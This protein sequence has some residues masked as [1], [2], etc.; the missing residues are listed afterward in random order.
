MSG[1]GNFGMP[2]Q[3]NRDSIRAD[4]PMNYRGVDMDNA[5]G[6]YNSFDI[7]SHVDNLLQQNSS[8][9]SIA[10]SNAQSMFPRGP[11]FGE[12][13]GNDLL[14]LDAVGSFGG[15][16]LTTQS[17]V[18]P[19][20][21]LGRKSLLYLKIGMI[22]RA[23]LADPTEQQIQVLGM[24][25][26]QIKLV[27]LIRSVSKF[28]SKCVFVL[29][30]GSGV[31]SCDYIVADELSAFAA[32]RLQALT[33]VPDIYVKVYGTVN[34]YGKRIPHIQV[35]AIR[36]I[37]N[38][39][40]IVLH[41]IEVCHLIRKRKSYA[42]TPVGSDVSTLRKSTMEGLSA[43]IQ[44]MSHGFPQKSISYA[45][46]AVPSS[47]P[48]MTHTA[49][50]VPSITAPGIM[51]PYSTQP[52]PS[53]QPMYGSY[54]TPNMNIARGM[55]ADAMHSASRIP[56]HIAEETQQESIPHVPGIATVVKGIL[57]ETN[58]S[59]CPDGLHRNEIL[60]RVKEILP[61]P[62]VTEKLIRN[63]LDMLER[64]ALVCTTS[65]SENYRSTG[66]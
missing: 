35:L 24:H 32:K 16:F 21:S 63:T 42:A 36:K 39:D 13:P 7:P 47:P 64:D 29:D 2:F 51:F 62:N 65:T 22:N 50:A 18:Q 6:S 41:D 52:L 1:A 28:E 49:A 45:D 26:E 54:D 57:V 43:P 30:D 17:T 33:D 4:T 31:I 46:S 15:G 19:Q 58:Y 25:V 34:L 8:F 20:G 40:E 56:S 44:S 14:G 48:R 66:P 11:T 23:W 3:M 37:D 61:N 55:G 9:G 12:L 27:G 53:K 10:P 38:P 59:A 60:R 5:S